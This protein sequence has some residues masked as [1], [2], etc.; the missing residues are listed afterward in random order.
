[1]AENINIDDIVSNL[2]QPH[3]IK[4]ILFGSYAYG[5]PSKNSDIDLMVITEHSTLPKNFREKMDFYHDVYKYIK[6]FTGIYPIDLIVYT[7][8][9]YNAFIES[10]SMFSKEIVSKGKV[11][12]E[13]N[14]Y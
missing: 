8:A 6:S 9:M 1:M 7:K 10:K 2:K 12:Y 4:V 11:L 3:I 14:N 5:T 13:K